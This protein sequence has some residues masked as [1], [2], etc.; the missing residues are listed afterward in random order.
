MCCCAQARLLDS[1]VPL[2]S[3]YV[4]RIHNEFL[5][6][7]F[8]MKGMSKESSENSAVKPFSPNDPPISTCLENFKETMS[9][10]RVLG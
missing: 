4:A 3:R 8:L 10:V 5:C 2:D 6:Q 1:S 7:R 9:T